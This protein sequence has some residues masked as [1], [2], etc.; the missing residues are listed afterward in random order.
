M[1]KERKMS[2]NTNTQ[3][4]IFDASRILNLLSCPLGYK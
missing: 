4:R 1:G 3:I 2:A